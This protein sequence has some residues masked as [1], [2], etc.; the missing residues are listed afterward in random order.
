MKNI[1]IKVCGMTDSN[2]LND[3]LSN[4]PDYIGIIHYEKSKRHVA[5]EN[6]TSLLNLTQNVKTVLVAVNLELQKLISLLDNYPFDYVQLHGEEDVDYCE[7]LKIHLTRPLSPMQHGSPQAKII[8]AFAVNEA[9]DFNATNQFEQVVDLFLFDTKGKLKGGNGTKF[10][11][12]ILSKYT[13]KK[14]FLLSGGIGPADVQQIKEFSHSK[15]AG[16]DLNSG[17]E[18]EP[19]IKN[20][21]S[22]QQFKNALHYV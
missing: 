3:V 16:I 13:G 17:F 6:F 2:N 4:N 8:K 15:L 7:A 20:I 18:I 9:F 12:D 14:P 11:W 5:E 19:G 1:D 10:N 22:L 21:E